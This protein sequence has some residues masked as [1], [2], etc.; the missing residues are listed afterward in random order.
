LLIDPE[1]ITNRETLWD[2][3]NEKRDPVPEIG[4]SIIQTAL[5]CFTNFKELTANPHRPLKSVGRVVQ[6]KGGS[7]QAILP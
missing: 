3:Q 5:R 6:K 2:R 1:R 4:T 7:R